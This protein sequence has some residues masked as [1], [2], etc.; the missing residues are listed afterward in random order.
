MNLMADLDILMVLYVV[1]NIMASVSY[2]PQTMTLIK[3]KTNSTSVAI[4]SWALWL[5]SSC[6]SLTYFMTRVKDPVVIF[7]SSVNLCGCLTVFSL[8]LFNRYI[9]ADG[10]SIHEIFKGR[11]AEQNEPRTYP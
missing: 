4:S 9:K 5:S 10:V 3:D 11:A 8:L 6:I 2:I 1:A 7:S